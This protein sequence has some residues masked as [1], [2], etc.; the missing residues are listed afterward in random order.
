[1][2]GE[3]SFAE[4]EK[5][6]CISANRFFTLLLKYGGISMEGAKMTGRTTHARGGILS[7]TG[8]QMP[9]I[10]TYGSSLPN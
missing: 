5:I 9:T 3:L 1:V 10:S 8:G 2:L 4:N 6:I 7:S